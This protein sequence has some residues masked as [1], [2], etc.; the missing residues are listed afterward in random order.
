MKLTT[1][2][3][4]IALAV[5]AALGLSGCAAISTEM[6][7][8]KLTTES[9]MSNSIMLDPV[10]DVHKVIY[11][12]VRD[13]SG[14]KVDLKNAITTS[15]KQKGWKITHDVAKAHDMLQVNVLQ[16]GKAPNLRAVWQSMNSGYSS[17]LLGGFAGVA[18]G[19]ATD[20]V[21]TGVGVGVAT[22]AVSW[23]ANE[24]VKDVT[25]SMITD[26]QVSVR[27]NGVVK[28]STRSNLSEGTQTSI[29]Q[30]YNK[31]TPW[32]RYRARV[33]SVADKVNLKFNDA[34]RTLVQE[35]SNEIAG[36]FG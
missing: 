4:I 9:K 36:I 22:G 35:V 21:G 24:M 7:H 16:A 15:L 33:A 6:H 34:K 1:T 12:Q 19:L 3:P 23:V 29:K 30:T 28:Q 8:G 31:K 27:V 14:Q 11:V 2:S 18:A 26:V 10:S 25:Y 13:T 32:I 5:T 20:D 17:A